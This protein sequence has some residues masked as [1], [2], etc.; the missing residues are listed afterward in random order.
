MQYKRF[1]A[2]I[3]FFAFFIIMPLITFNFNPKCYAYPANYSASSSKTLLDYT[4]E[5]IKRNFEDVMTE[6]EIIKILNKKGIKKYS[7]LSFPFS[8]KNQKLKVYFIKIIQPDGNIMHINLNNLKTVTAPFNQEAPIFSNQLLKTVQIPGLTKGSILDYKFRSIA[9]KPYM[10]NNFFTED[11][12]GGLAPLKKS[13]YKL[14]IP[15]DVHYRYTEYGFKEKP[16]IIKNSKNITLVWSL[17]NRNK[18]TPEPM[19][20]GESFIVP[21]VTVSSVKSW[22]KVAEW[23]ANLTKDIIKPGNQLKDFIK[24]ITASKKTNLEKIKSV[25]DFVAKRIRYVGY[26]FGIDGYKP[27][28]VNAIF[29]N[30]LGDCKDHATLFATMLKQIGVKAY[31]VL[32]PTTE[33]PDMNPYMPTPFVFDHE[34]TAIKLKSGKFMF[35]DTTSNVT[36]FGDLPPMD[37]GRNVLII[38]NGKAVIAR[39]PIFPPSKNYISD[40]EYASVYANGSIK[41]RAVI[42]YGGAYDMY[43]RYLYSSLSAKKKRNEVLKNIMSIAPYAKLTNYS[44]E[45]GDSMTKPYIEKFSFTAKKYTGKNGKKI[46]VKIPLRARNELA[47]I[48]A[49]NKRKYP[50]KFG[51]NFSEKTAVKINFPKN[52]KIIYIPQSVNFKNK[53]GSFRT[54]YSIKNGALI[55]NSIFSVFGYKIKPANYNA[56]KKLFN[57]TIKTLA[58][59]VLIFNER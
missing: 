33:I 18:L 50:I 25:Y 17:W 8:S 16:E 31:P 28:D 37:Q 9:L 46:M 23:Y 38:D 51:Y 29:K 4:A 21:H 52:Y 36:T 22:N 43:K 2:A 57:Y 15:D 6:H 30:R 1:T 53:V 7:S 11:Y 34:I 14:T 26:E 19:G 48:T 39:T 59:Q 41:V 49:L 40:K 47:K 13:V 27:S 10:K 44:F 32:I 20:P 3:V 54:A 58:S 12:F 56:A 24:K 55:F 5:T 45:N 35:A 42:N